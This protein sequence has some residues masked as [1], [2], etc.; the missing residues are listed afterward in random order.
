[1][2]SS[3]A[4]A[5]ILAFDLGSFN[6]ID[7]DLPLAQFC[8]YPD[9]DPVPAVE[10]GGFAVLVQQNPLL[11]HQLATGDGSARRLSDFIDQDQLHSLDLYRLIYKVL[12][13]EYQMA[14][15]LAVKS[16]LVVAIVLNRFDEDFTDSEVAAF[17]AWRPYLTQSYRNLNALA[18]LRSI[19]DALSDVGRAAVVL[20]DKGV[21]AGCPKW[22]LAAIEEHFG[23]APRAGLPEVVKSWVNE[24]RRGAINDGR[25][26]LMHPV[27]SKHRDRELVLRF[28]RGSPGRADVILVDEREAGREVA[29]LRRIGLTE[30][31]AEVL[32]LFVKGEATP[33]LARSLGISVGTVNKHLQNI[34]RKL[35]VSNRTAALVAASEAL[36]SFR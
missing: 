36:V 19:S 6:E 32:S 29:E 2:A 21:E 17:D 22:A 15:G 20:S 35:G 13:V 31:E 18:S 11:Q 25:P 5:Q 14:I 3:R 23:D 12:R 30:R 34:Y 10:S 8:A 33:V 28:V 16:P 27:S 7:P 24:Q 9:E 4:P 26:K 1:M